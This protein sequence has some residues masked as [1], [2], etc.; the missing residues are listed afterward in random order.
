M[1]DALI[2][3]KLHGKPERRT[4]KNGNAYVIAKVR[5][6]TDADAMFASVIC[7]DETAQAA[8]LALD[9]GDPV[10]LAGALNVKPWLDREGNPRANLNIIA[11]AVLTPY[12]AKRKR[13]AMQ[14]GEASEGQSL[15][16]RRNVD[17]RVEEFE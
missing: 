5:V 10:A 12:H 8:L 1:I 14:A 7:F 6:P 11:T 16:G 13:E 2:G 15:A 3:G 4:A 17:T 9:A